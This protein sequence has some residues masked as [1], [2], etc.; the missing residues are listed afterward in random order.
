MNA[1]IWRH[2]THIEI[3]FGFIAD[4][5]SLVFSAF[6]NLRKLDFHG[7]ICDFF[8]LADLLEGRRC[9]MNNVQLDGEKK[10]ESLYRIRDLGQH[11]YSNRQF[12]A[13]NFSKNSLDSLCLD[14]EVL[15][16]LSRVCFHVSFWILC[17]T[18][19]RILCRT[20]KQLFFRR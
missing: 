13:E 5:S 11:P 7:G 14:V 6:P 9:Q 1:D 4:F 15:E 8:L 10:L 2:V 19:A 16:Y 20:G 12:S 3:C 17:S 18:R